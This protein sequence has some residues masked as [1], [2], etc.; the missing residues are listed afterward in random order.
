MVQQERVAVGLG[1]GH[2][3]R[4]QGAAG[5]ADV[6]DHR[7]AARACALIASATSRATVSVGPPAA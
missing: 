5:A 7:P 3:A 1:L 2:P 4:A 6:L